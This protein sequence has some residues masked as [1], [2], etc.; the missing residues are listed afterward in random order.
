MS[1]D[2]FSACAGP[3]RV[4]FI[5]PAA[6]GLPPLRWWDELA[7]L[8]EIEGA[9]VEFLVGEKATIDRVAKALRTGTDIAIV[10]AHGVANQIVLADGRRI[11]G[12]WLATQARRSPPECIVVGACFSGQ[13]DHGFESIGEAISQAG[14]H[15]LVFET[16]VNDSA[17]AV[18]STEFVRAMA[19]V[20]DVVRASRVASASAAQ[21]NEATAGA[22]RLVPGVV[23]GYRE[24]VRRFEAIECQIR[25]LKSGQDRLLALV[26]HRPSA[27]G[28]G[29]AAGGSE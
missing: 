22:A 10:S 15:A 29:H 24:F 26:E 14:I 4:L 8:G 2:G 11:N 16:E 20:F 7:E 12:E 3:V 17:G 19:A 1:R 27:N 9:R 5:G 23:N 28:T 6:P 25:D 21:V 18:Y 13:R